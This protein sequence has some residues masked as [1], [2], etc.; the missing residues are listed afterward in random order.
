VRLFGMDI[1][2]LTDTELS[3]LRNRRIG[4]VFQFYHLLSEFTVLEN[5][6]MPALISA[7]RKARRES[8]RGR[9][10]ELLEKIGLCERVHHFPGQLSGG[11]QQRVALAR[12]LMNKPELL[13]CDEPTGNLDSATGQAIIGLILKIQRESAMTVVLVTHNM[14]LAACAQKVY[15]LKDGLLVH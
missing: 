10:L 12:A 6:C 2:A 7:G 11:E 5:V 15:Y 3:A 4:F 14:E 13:L 1:Y 9:A 8:I